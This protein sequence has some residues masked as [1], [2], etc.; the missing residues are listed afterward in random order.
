M[1]E[2]KE[3]ITANNV[4]LA[5]QW[6][7]SFN[8]GLEYYFEPAGVVSVGAF[9]TKIKDFIFSKTN[10]VGNGADNGFDGLYPGYELR[11][12]DNGGAATIKGIELNYNQQLVFLPGWLSGL[13]VFGN[14]T[15]LKTNGDYG[16]TSASPVT[17][18]AGFV[19]KSANIGIA[20][21]RWGLDIRLKSTYKGKWLTGYSTNAGAVRYTH[22]RSNLDL[23]I[24]YRFNPRYSVYFDW[25]NIENEA[26]AIDY[27]YRPELVRTNNPTG[28]RFNLGARVKF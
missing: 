20:L 5:P 8:V 14:Y 27:Q 26:E 2:E 15:Q 23:N 13:S 9:H 12:K 1:N 10:N 4:G 24:L 11:T 7:D 19:P 22:A 28:S 3:I 25:A 6:G 17:E 18:L 16:G 21:T